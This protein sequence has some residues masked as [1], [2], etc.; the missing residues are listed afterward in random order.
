MHLGMILQL[1]TLFPS[2]QHNKVRDLTAVMMS[3][4]C[5]NIS[6]E[7]HLQP[8]SGEAPH[9]EGLSIPSLM[10]ES[11]TLV[12]HLIIHLSLLT[13]TMRRRGVSMSNMCVRL[14]MTVRV[15]LHSFLL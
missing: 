4:M 7:P 10:L 11:L 9:L 3:E 5:T 13:A 6:T 14:S 8:I 15:L 1:I 12:H 2:L